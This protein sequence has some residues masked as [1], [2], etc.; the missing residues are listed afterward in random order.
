MTSKK[1]LIKELRKEYGIDLDTKTINS[2][3]AEQIQEAIEDIK[4]IKK[5]GFNYQGNE[6]YKNTKQVR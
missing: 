1:E 6:E 2:M 3:S 4:N 5:Y